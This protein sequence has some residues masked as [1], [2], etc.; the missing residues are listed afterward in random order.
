MAVLSYEEVL[1]KGYSICRECEEILARNRGSV[2][3]EGIDRYP[4]VKP[5]MWRHSERD[6]YHAW[7]MVE[8]RHVFYAGQMNSMR[9]LLKESDP[10]KGRI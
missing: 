10:L 8:D 2:T 3:V 7:V 9:N 6:Y 1:E 4:D 5:R